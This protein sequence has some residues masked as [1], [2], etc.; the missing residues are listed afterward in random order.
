MKVSREAQQG[1]AAAESR[2]ASRRSRLNGSR[3]ETAASAI[4]KIEPVSH[5]AEQRRDDVPEAQ[6]ITPRRL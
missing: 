2:I 3:R 6:A 5:G 1:T 4:A